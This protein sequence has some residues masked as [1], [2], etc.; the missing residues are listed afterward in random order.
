MKLT[1]VCAIELYVLGAHLLHGV[2]E[3][4]GSCNRTYC[5]HCITLPDNEYA[6]SP[7]TLKVRTH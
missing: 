4:H 5:L 2:C 7:D 6:I 1:T 3:Y